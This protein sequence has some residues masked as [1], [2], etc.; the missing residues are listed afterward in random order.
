MTC[1]YIHVSHI[2]PIFQVLSLLSKLRQ[3]YGGKSLVA[4]RLLMVNGDLDPWH[5]LSITNV[6]D[7]G[8]ALRSDQVCFILLIARDLDGF[9]FLLEYT[10]RDI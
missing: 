4:D 3:Y 10:N 5:L 6:S 9:W 1:F 7:I 8:C 2:N